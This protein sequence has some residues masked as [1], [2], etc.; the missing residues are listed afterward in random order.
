MRM[1]IAWL[2]ALIFCATLALVAASLDLGPTIKTA[3]C[4]STCLRH[5]M[6]DGN[7]W[8]TNKTDNQT[9]DCHKVIENILYHIVFL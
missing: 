8:N 7:C 6:I 5:H 3:Q 4:G 1:K 2:P 9:S